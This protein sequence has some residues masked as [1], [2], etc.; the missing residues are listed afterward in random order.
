ME[1][2][3]LGTAVIRGNRLCRALYLGLEWQVRLQRREAIIILK[4]FDVEEIYHVQE[5]V[6]EKLRRTKQAQRVTRK[7]FLHRP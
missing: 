3:N 7:K 2:I 1:A 5:I 4:T 6:H